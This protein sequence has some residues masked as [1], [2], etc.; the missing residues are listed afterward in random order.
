VS[1]LARP[2]DPTNAAEPA[3][4]PEPATPRLVGLAFPAPAPASAAPALT[5]AGVA[6]VTL[7]S[8]WD[9]VASAAVAST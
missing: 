4:A 5:L 2:S 6:L 1:H 3:A 8:L 7:E 9:E